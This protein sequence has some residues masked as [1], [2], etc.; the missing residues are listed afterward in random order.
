TRKRSTIS[1]HI[2]SRG[3]VYR[4][5]CRKLRLSR[6]V[7]LRKRIA[8]ISSMATLEHPSR[9]RSGRAACHSVS[10]Y[11]HFRGGHRRL[12]K[13][14]ARGRGKKGSSAQTNPVR[15]KM[16]SPPQKLKF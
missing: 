11:V 15:P 5:F 9:V 1:H 10:Y 16:E 8:N 2:A 14:G 7:S 12:A 3:A 13:A 6:R 4:T